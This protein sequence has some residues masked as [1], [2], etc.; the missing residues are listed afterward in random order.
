MCGT[1]R[2]GHRKHLRLSS[3]IEGQLERVARDKLDLC[4][5]GEGAGTGGTLKLQ[6]NRGGKG[7]HLYTISK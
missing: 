2:R 1:G 7:S 6:S 4:N 3:P 5:G